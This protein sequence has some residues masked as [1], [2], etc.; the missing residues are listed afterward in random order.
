M[1]LTH[2][3]FST[4]FQDQLLACMIR[5]PEMFIGM[6]GVIDFGY[7]TGTNSQ[8][9]CKQMQNFFKKHNTYPNFAQLVTLV[10]QATRQTGDADKSAEIVA[11][12]QK[13][14]EVEIRAKEFYR[15]QAVSFAKQR[16]LIL[17]ATDVAKLIQEGKEPGP[18]IVKKFQDALATGQNLLDQGYLLKQDY[19]EIIDKVTASDYGTY[20][21]FDL[22][23]T[24]LWPKGWGPGWL[25]VPLAPPKRYKC[26]S[27]D[28]PVLMYD[29][30]TKHIC[31]V[32]VGDK[33]MG[34]DSTARTVLSCGRGRGPMYKVTQSNGD[35][36][37]VTHD[38]ILCLK[39]LEHTVP[40]GK[41]F[42]N[43]YH[44]GDVLEIKAED[45]ARK[46]KWF[47]RTWQGYKVGVEFPSAAVPIDPYFI[48]L[49]LG[50]ASST[51]VAID[52][53]DKDAESVGYA[54]KFDKNQRL[55]VRSKSRSINA[56]RNKRIPEVYKINSRH[57][58]LQ[59]LA[60]MIDSVREHERCR[61][62]TFVNTNEKLCQ[63]TCWIARSLGFKSFVRKVKTYRIVHGKKLFSNA[64][65]TYIQGKISE[66]PTKLPRKRGVDSAKASN[67]TSIEVKY[68][69][70]RE[71]FGVEL[72]GNRRYLHGDFTVTHNTAF[73]LNLAMN[74]VG[75]KCGYDV[76]YYACEISAELAALRTFQAIVGATQDEVH[77]NPY[78]FKHRL[79][80]EL[81]VNMVGDLLIKHY[82]AKTASIADIRAH[83]VSCVETMGMKPRAIFIDYAETIKTDNS[84]DVPEYRQQ[85]DVY[86]QARALGDELGCVV[87]M[88]DRCNREAVN[89]A[90]PSMDSFQGAFEKAGIVD[91]SIGLCATDEEYEKGDLR[92]FT[93]LNRH[94]E[95]GTHLKGK[96]D[97]KKMRISIDEELKG[98]EVAEVEAQIQAQREKKY[99]GRR[100]GRSG[101]AS[102]R[103]ADPRLEVPAPSPESRTKRPFRV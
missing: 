71:W 69:G 88:P 77:D 18:E 25:V 23:D 8:I 90:T 51:T 76:L 61:S 63:D 95:G 54:Y 12:V 101:L 5:H 44:S 15:D 96:I 60:G 22:F 20:T 79:Y 93:V 70:N 87:I 68:V 86:T 103:E 28:T 17:A 85:S 59:V 100:G 62:L 43:R 75:P 9:A 84:K 45:Y 74:M 66:I 7:F 72:D 14:S 35:S 36:Y 27:P 98:Y 39:R 34:D 26:T 67:R 52:M 42:K 38:H 92:F 102:S 65:R 4:D 33:L 32:K 50:G 57:V 73:C 53:S 16:A 78:A 49:W 11:Y 99:G 81:T 29:G 37:T 2:Y 89:Q 19:I 10:L 46:P 82:P 97:R 13:L 94:G 6:P 40:T 80:D 83:A 31:E 91:I 55:K 47:K 41:R 3:N 24:K 56:I 64:Y 30:S 58:R 21:G 48:G 1:A